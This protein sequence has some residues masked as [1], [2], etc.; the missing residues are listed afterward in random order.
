M[1]QYLLT[2]PQNK[3][4]KILVLSCDIAHARFLAM[5]L[6]MLGLSADYVDSKLSTSRN[7]TKIQKFRKNS[8]R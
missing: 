8:R 2:K 7:I 3:R 5:W 1:I 4:K 6:K